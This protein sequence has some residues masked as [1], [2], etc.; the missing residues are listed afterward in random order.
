MDIDT[1]GCWKQHIS[2]SIYFPIADQFIN[3]ICDMYMAIFTPVN[4]NEEFVL[5]DNCYNVCKGRAI[6]Y[7][8]ISTGKH[9][10][11]CPR[12]HKFAP[13]S[14]RLMIILQ[15]T[16]LP[17]PLEDVD[18]AIKRWRQFQRQLYIDPIFGSGIKSILED[19]P[20]QKALNNYM[21]IVD[22]RLAPRPEWNQRLGIN[23]SFCF[24]IFSVP[25]R[26]VRTIN[27]LLIDL[28]YHSSRIIFNQK[29]IFLD[30]MEWYL[31]EPCEVGKNLTGENAFKQL[32][33]IEGLSNFKSRQGREISPK[34][35]FWPSDDRD[36]SQLQLK[37]IAGAQCLEGV[38]LK[39][40]GIGFGFDAIYEK[41]GITLTSSSTS[42]F[43]GDAKSSVIGGTVATLEE[44]MAMTN[45]MLQI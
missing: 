44:D 8:N 35:A 5:T 24:T 2:K 1:E 43:T 13:I 22:G 37:N 25:T 29:D 9:V 28:A 23:D 39:E 12:F 11:I 31:T 34:M 33:Y 20:I 17:E 40:D 26:Y 6:T 21:E 32:Q 19:V 36:L 7:F 41:L 42:L 3:H 38:R 18:P 16:H 45:T 10:S 15:S 14:P 4:Y 27:G 30:L